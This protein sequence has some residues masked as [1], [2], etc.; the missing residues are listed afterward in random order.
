[1]YVPICRLPKE[2]DPKIKRGDLAMEM[3]LGILLR[4]K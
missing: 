3:G 2:T 4:L 1:L